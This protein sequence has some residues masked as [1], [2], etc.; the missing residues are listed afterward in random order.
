MSQKNNVQNSRFPPPSLFLPVLAENKRSPGNR[1]K[2]TRKKR[3][4]GKGGGRQQRYIHINPL[5]IKTIDFPR[6]SSK[7]AR[8][9]N[10]FQMN[11]MN[12]LCL[13]FFPPHACLIK[14]INVLKIRDL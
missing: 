9:Y 11:I 3:T 2:G 14:V 5:G 8:F 1:Q 7:Q 12:G 4:A 10:D 13:H 6:N